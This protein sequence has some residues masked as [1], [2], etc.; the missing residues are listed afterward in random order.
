[1]INVVLYT[2]EGC[3]LCAEAKQDLT[4]LQTAYPHRLAEVDIT[5]DPALLARYRY[6]IPVVRVGDIEL[7]APVTAAQLEAALAA[8]SGG[9]G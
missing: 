4:R 3:G 8:A 2:K 7:Q 5:G 6:T 9:G 1:M